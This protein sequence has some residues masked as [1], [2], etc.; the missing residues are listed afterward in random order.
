VRALIAAAALLV[1]GACG[2]KIPDPV[3]YLADCA[4]SDFV[5][6]PDGESQFFFPPA[7]CPIAA[8]GHW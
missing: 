6:A 2:L 4:T 7:P 5:P 8:P 1:L 3:P